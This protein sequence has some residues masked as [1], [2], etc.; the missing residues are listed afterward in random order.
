MLPNYGSPPL[1]P[2]DVGQT[3]LSGS[4]ISGS[5]IDR[6]VCPTVMA[7]SPNFRIICCTCRWAFAG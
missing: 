7:V 6:N 2:I 5:T 1:L 3:F 4:G